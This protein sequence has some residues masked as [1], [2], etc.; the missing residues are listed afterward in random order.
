[1]PAQGKGTST[2][3]DMIGKLWPKNLHRA[4]VGLVAHPA[5]INRKLVHARDVLNESKQLRVAALF[6]PQHGIHGQTQDNMIEW[7]SFR[8]TATGLPVYSL[9]GKVRKPTPGMLDGID[10]LVIDLQDVGSRYYT[11]IWT[12]ELCM[13]A[14]YEN[15]KAVVVL[16]RPNPLGGRQTEGPVLDPA[17]SSFVGMR[18]L[19]V[20]HGMTIGEIGRYLK[21][22]SYPSLDYHVLVM[23]EWKRTLWFDQTGLPWVMPSPNMPTLDTALV[24]PGMCLLEGTNLSEGRG[25]T[26]PFEIFGAP[27]IHPGTIVQVLDD[28]GLPG[29]LFRPLS[30]EPTF[31]KHAGRLCGGAQIHVTNREKFRPFKTGVAVLKAIHDTYPRDF[32]WKKPPYEYEETKLPIDILAG[33]DRLRR[34]IDAGSDLDAMENWWN[35]ESQ[36]FEKIRKKHLIYK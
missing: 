11:F 14:C 23:R 5:S 12:L 8:D 24:Y 33:R 36:Q 30:F 22:A 15:G 20:R 27:F 17:F 26:R 28:F 1:M 9:Y 32:A 21:E 25:T 7:E 29:V 2:G 35:K 13:Q 19:T 31:Q 6:G 3:L 18:P 34:D 4:R 10:A 16:D